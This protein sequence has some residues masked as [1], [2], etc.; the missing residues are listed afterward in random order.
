MH[1]I[2]SAGLMNSGQ[3]LIYMTGVNMENLKTQIRLVMIL[4]IL[5]FLAGGVGH[6]ALTDIY[7]GEVDVSLEW[8]VLRICAFILLVFIGSAL[9]TLRKVI[10]AL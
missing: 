3:S 5:A 10:R 8:I 7:H 2:V 4:G 9:F 1:P 6:L